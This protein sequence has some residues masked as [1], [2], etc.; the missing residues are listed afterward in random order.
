M[1]M[2]LFHTTLAIPEKR[3]VH[4][5]AF[6]QEVHARLHEAR[7]SESGDPIPPVAAAIARGLKVLAFDEMVVNNS[8]DAMIMSRLFRALICD[9]GLGERL[10]TLEDPFRLYRCHTIMNCA[11]VCP[12][13]LNPAAAIV[14]IRKLMQDREV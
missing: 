3:R 9:E 1:L 13:G 5:H 6:M 10:D 7:Q 2:D 8:A 11:N 14:E 12:K 4:F